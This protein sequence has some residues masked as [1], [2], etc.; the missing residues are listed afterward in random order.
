MTN[1]GK[2]AGEVNISAA[3][4]V[5]ARAQGGTAEREEVNDMIKTLQDLQNDPVAPLDTPEI[6][7]TLAGLIAARGI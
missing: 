1:E 2:G 5:L 6:R 7:T 4:D 3:K